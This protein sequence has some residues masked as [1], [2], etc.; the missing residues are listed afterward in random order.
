LA[1]LT[2]YGRLESLTVVLE[3]AENAVNGL[4]LADNEISK[5]ETTLDG[6]ND[7]LKDLDTQLKKYE[8]LGANARVEG[9]SSFTRSITTR[10]DSEVFVNPVSPPK[11]CWRLGSNQVG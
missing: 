11:V 4:D 3:G 5:F 6:C 1:Y 8:R 9:Q 2:V 7:V 10:E